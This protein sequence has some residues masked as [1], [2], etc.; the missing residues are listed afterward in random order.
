MESKIAKITTVIFMLHRELLRIPLYLC[1]IFSQETMPN[2]HEHMSEL[3]TLS[4]DEQIQANDD[5]REY[6]DTHPQKHASL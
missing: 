5:V 2:K 6:E 3:P 1:L 4:K